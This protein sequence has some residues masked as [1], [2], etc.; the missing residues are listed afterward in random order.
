VNID[1]TESKD[2][3]HSTRRQFFFFFS[4]MAPSP[5]R[6]SFSHERMLYLQPSTLESHK[7]WRLRAP[8]EK[9]R[10][11]CV[12]FVRNREHTRFL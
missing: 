12:L 5:S 4:T 10:S 7:R 2:R 3:V 6:S 1:G 9:V 11:S 8:N